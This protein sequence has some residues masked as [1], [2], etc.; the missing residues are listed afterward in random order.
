MARTDLSKP[1]RRRKVSATT[2]DRAPSAGETRA[3]RQPNA[4]ENG[5][6]PPAP[7]EAEAT[8]TSPAADEPA[9]ADGQ[10]GHDPPQAPEPI[11][12]PAVEASADP[13]NRVEGPAELSTGPQQLQSTPDN[14][15]PEATPK[16]LILPAPAPTGE[17]R[18][19]A[20]RLRGL[21]AK[22]A[23]RF[24]PVAFDH[25]ERLGRRAHALGSSH[26]A[27]GARLWVR[28]NQYLDDFESRF[29]AS[30][31]RALQDAKRLVK[32]GLLRPPQARRGLEQGLWLR[33]RQLARRYPSQEQR[34]RE[35]VYNDWQGSV[36]AEAERRGLLSPLP[37]AAEAPDLE[38]PRRDPA[39]LAT[40]LYHD[41]VSS[42]QARLAIAR[43][44]EQLPVE[45]GRY[46]A[47]SVATR[48]LQ[49]MQGAP[50]YLKAQLSRLESLALLTSYFTPQDTSDGAR[51]DKRGTPP[52]SAAQKKQKP[53][54]PSPPRKQGKAGATR[55]E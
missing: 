30:R 31:A 25:A 2:E 7:L 38:T 34:T 16:A 48:A 45:A 6:A 44:V 50:P 14:P 18:A 8:E 5:S 1:R 15:P 12:P 4:G 37:D 3:A 17:S 33:L 43:A 24:D 21:Q 13:T 9:P 55:P 23:H 29:S 35:R 46:H 19:F 36:A 10:V 54:R 22:M 20:A 53:R 42:L 27:A 11:D 51:S 49:A 26:P 47:T 39:G 40:A 28:A 32:L 52:R 41:A